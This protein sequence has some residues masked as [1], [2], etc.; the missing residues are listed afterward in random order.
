MR[1]IAIVV[2]QDLVD[3]SWRQ[4]LEGEGGRIAARAGGCVAALAAIK[5]RAG[6][7]QPTA[8]ALRVGGAGAID[9]G[10]GRGNRRD[11]HEGQ[12]VGHHE[13]I[14]CIG[15]RDQKRAALGSIG[16]ERLPLL[17]FCG[18]LIRGDLLVELH[19][20]QCGCTV[21]DRKGRVAG[22]IA[23]GVPSGEEL[24]ALVGIEAL[25]AERGLIATAAGGSVAAL[26]AIQTGAAPGLPDAAGLAVG[27]VQGVDDLEGGG[28]R[29]VLFDAQAGGRSG[30]RTEGVAE[31]RLVEV[32]VVGGAGREAVGGRGRAAD[33]DIVRAVAAHFPLHGRCGVSAGRRR[34]GHCAACHDRLI[35]RIRGYRG[36]GLN[37]QGGRG[38]RGRTDTVAEDRLVLVAVLR[39]SC[40]EAIG[41]RGRAANGAESSAAVRAGL[42][43]QAG[44][45][46]AA[47]GRREAGRV[48]RHDRLVGGL[49]AHRRGV[50][51]RQG[52][53]RAGRR[54]G[55]VRENGLVL[56]TVLPGDRREAVG[57]RGR[58]ADRA[59]G[60]AAVDADFPLHGGCGVAGSRRR[61]GGR[62]PA[63]TISPAGLVVTVGA[64]STV[65]AAGKVVA[66][67]TL[68]LKMASYSI[69][70]LQS[71][72]REAVGRRCRAADGT[73]VHAVAAHLPL[74]GGGGVAAGGGRERGRVACN[75]RLVGRFVVTAGGRL[76]DER[77][78][79]RSRRTHEVRENGLVLVAVLRSNG[80][81]AVGGRVC[82]A[83]RG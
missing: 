60:I 79:R 26:A 66:E 64:H 47:G 34:E 46:V 72:R 49:G 13:T 68:L 42:P 41:R 16:P 48:A 18:R 9:H 5:A 31:D 78:G 35:G 22:V 3:L 12:G 62:M 55:D 1:G 33:G 27:R 17:A 75:D 21:K 82:A 11:L 77:G 73:E 38:G 58:S 20:G 83:D 19:R 57:A 51:Y 4:V 2:D 44:R 24:I 54:A 71:G 28:G 32:A 80:R 39:G 10:R 6:P 70:I 14:G 50:V 25:E 59:E 53:S 30:G 81:E 7:A 15:E 23:G 36:R 67:P 37:G 45:G 43:L 69:A 8:A 56:V 52:R 29:E 74:H 61:K 65:S 76:D 40:R 63:T